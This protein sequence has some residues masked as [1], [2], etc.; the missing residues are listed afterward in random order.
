M[1]NDVAP[2]SDT[3]ASRALR[4]ATSLFWIDLFVMLATLS[5]ALSAF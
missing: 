5:S 2:T 4:R 3:G 1:M